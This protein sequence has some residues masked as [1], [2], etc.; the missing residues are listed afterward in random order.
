MALFF[1]AGLPPLSLFSLE[2]EYLFLVPA[3]LRRAELPFPFAAG[4]SRP[5][6]PLAAAEPY[7]LSRV[8]APSAYNRHGTPVLPPF[9]ESS[10]RKWKFFPR[11]LPSRENF[12]L[13]LLTLPGRTP[14][15]LPPRTLSSYHHS[16]LRGP[17]PLKTVSAPSS[18]NS[19][20]RLPHPRTN[21]PFR[22]LFA[23][24]CK[25][26]HAPPEDQLLLLSLSVPTRD[27][28]LRQSI[29]NP[30]FPSE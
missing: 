22:L 7:S 23:A 5:F 4:T 17:P 1:K 11:L 12:R 20:F 16:L 15:K 29:Q 14:N 25:N 2:V 28:P 13:L 19:P 26:P 18:H 3:C 21:K 6:P 27:E 8:L 30:P 9:S 24:L 10:S